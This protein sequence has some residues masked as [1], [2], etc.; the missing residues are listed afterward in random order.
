M[1]N[2]KEITEN[3]NLARQNA[4]NRQFKSLKEFRDYLKDYKIPS[5]NNF[6][7]KLYG[8]LKDRRFTESP[9]Y[10]DRV[11]LIYNEIREQRKKYI[12][13]KVLTV[14]SAIQLLKSKGYK[15]LEPIVEYKE[16]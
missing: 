16:V 8:L 4:G 9:I 1:A 15:I 12:S 3:L 6:V 2:I 7:C 13:N 14:K 10:I 11:Q 5:N